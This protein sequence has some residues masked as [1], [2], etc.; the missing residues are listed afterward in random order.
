MNPV[1]EVEA[2]AGAAKL[3]G[4]GAIAAEGASAITS[5]VTTATEAAKVGAVTAEVAKMAEVA[6]AVGETGHVT[7][8]AE[9]VAS[10]LEQKLQAGAKPEDL[11]KNLAETPAE[12]TTQAGDVGKPNVEGTQASI[13]QVAGEVK[14]LEAPNT[15]PVA[16]VGGKPKFSPEQQKRI[17]TSVRTELDKWD[18]EHVEPNRDTNPEDYNKWIKDRVE[19]QNKF[20]VDAQVDRNLKEW[21]AKNPKPDKT[22]N[23]KEFNEWTKVRSEKEAESRE[24]YQE[25]TNATKEAKVQE[26]KDQKE[27][28]AKNEIY[29]SEIAETIKRLKELYV[30]RADLIEGIAILRGKTGKTNEDKLKITDYQ[31]R[32]EVTDSEIKI[33]EQEIGDEITRA[34]IPMKIAIITLLA[35]AKTVAVA[36]S[37]FKQT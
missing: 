33:L 13:Q 20:T 35:T 34:P 26:E 31:V 27:N 19:A 5:V 29:E 7:T 28:N 4:A 6:T 36:D 18:V 37:A 2:V 12:Q 10:S 9:N 14:A 32:K 21:E 11:L 24:Q 1:S 22:S 3:A 17:D 8:A 16:E 25:N 30:L 15:T 23:P